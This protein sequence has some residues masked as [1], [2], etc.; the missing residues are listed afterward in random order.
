MTTAATTTA[1]VGTSGPKKPVPKVDLD[2]TRD[3]L[4]KLGLV[5]SAEQL[6]LKVTAAVKDPVS[7]HQFLDSVLD[8]ELAEREER[9]IRTS[10]KLSGLPTGQTLAN[11][12]FAFQ[13]SVERSRIETLGTC[14]WIREN[15]NL[16]LQG[17]PGVGKTHLAVSL[18]VR[19]V[20]NGFGVIFYRLEDLLAAMKRDADLSPTQLRRRKYMNVSLL[21]IDEVGFE[22]MSRT[23][24]SLFF[25]LVSY[26]YGRGSILITT[27]KGIRDWPEVLAG[28]EVLATAI[29]DRLL[30]KSH[31]LNIRGRSY[32]LRELEQRTESRS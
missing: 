30:H 14:A 3:R 22:P 31:V 19:A 10:M 18:G 13:P 29:L 5:H 8:A 6:E 9:R 16:L 20:E 12:D 17:P 11:F 24:A 15:H 7:P 4:L 21:V 25:R 28:D 1:R 32:R 23:E 26:R 27:N 2:T